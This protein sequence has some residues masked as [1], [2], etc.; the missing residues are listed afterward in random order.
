[1][2]QL[3]MIYRKAR[4]IRHS[5][6]SRHSALISEIPGIV[7]Q[8]F[9]QW[10]IEVHPI[11]T[12]NPQSPRGSEHVAPTPPPP[13]ATS[14]SNE[15]GPTPD[16]NGSCHDKPINRNDHGQLKLVKIFSGTSWTIICLEVVHISTFGQQNV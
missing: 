7:D 3:I 6:Y 15:H 11:R 9:C 2:N 10:H 5:L 4:L 8:L 12:E 16:F 13:D 14:T 1:M